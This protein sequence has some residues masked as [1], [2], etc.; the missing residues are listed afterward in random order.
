MEPY[1]ESAIVKEA[2]IYSYTCNNVKIPPRVI[3]NPKLKIAFF[4]HPAKIAWWHQVTVLPEVNKISVF[5]NGISKGLKAIIPVGGQIPP[6][7]AV[8]AKLE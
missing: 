4:L 8:G 6:I 5:N 3:V 2:S 7:S 1:T